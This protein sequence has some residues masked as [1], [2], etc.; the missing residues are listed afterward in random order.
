LANGK[1]VDTGDAASHEAVLVEL[2]VF[3]AVGAKP[4]PGVVVPLVGETNRDA[5]AL[6]SPEFL[7]EAI[8]QL[9]VPLAGKELVAGFATGQKLRAVAAD[10]VRGVSQGDLFRVARIPGI[11]G[12]ADL[13]GG[14]LG[15][16]W[17]KRWSRVFS[18]GHKTP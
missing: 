8:V 3:V 10:A 2:P 6:E 7:D 9:L 16:E 15:I 5:V 4:I 13:F 11:L 12:Q 1:V 18:C 17:R 14:G